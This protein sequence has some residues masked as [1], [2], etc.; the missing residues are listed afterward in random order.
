MNWF[1]K[2]TS[3]IVIDLNHFKILVRMDSHQNNIL[4]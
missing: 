4:R 3:L 1:S 2:K